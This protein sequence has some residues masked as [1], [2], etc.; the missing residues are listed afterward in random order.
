MKVFFFF[1]VEVEL[2]GQEKLVIVHEMLMMTG[3]VVTPIIYYLT[4]GIC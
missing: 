3:I 2:L 4:Y 1:I